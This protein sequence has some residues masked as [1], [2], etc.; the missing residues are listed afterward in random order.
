MGLGAVEL[1]AAPVEIGLDIAEGVGRRRTERQQLAMLERGAGRS[2]AAM[3]AAAEE[4]LIDAQLEMTQRELLT[5]MAR[6]YGAGV[7]SEEVI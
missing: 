5:R 4:A 7:D 3:G 2:E 6:K 1:A